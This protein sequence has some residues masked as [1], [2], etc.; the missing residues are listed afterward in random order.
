MS[1]IGKSRWCRRCK[2]YTLHVKD[3]PRKVG[4]AGHVVMTLFTCGL[5]AMVAPLIIGIEIWGGL[6]AP[7]RCQH[8]GKA[9]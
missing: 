5:W 2:K 8:C 3:E 7:Y 6:L 1:R 4:C 9:R